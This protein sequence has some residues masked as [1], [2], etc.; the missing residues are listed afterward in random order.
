M[1]IEESSPAVQGPLAGV[2]VLDLSR[3]ISGPFCAK[4]LADFGA[5]VI[6]IERPNGEEVRDVWLGPDG[7]SLYWAQY[8]ANKRAMTLDTRASEARPILRSLV[9]WADVLVEN[10]RPGTLTRMGLSDEELS[11]LNPQLIK[12]SISGFGQF[13]P[14]VDRPLFNAIAEATTGAMYLTRSSS[15]EPQMSGTFMADHAAGLY[16]TIGALLALFGRE[17][18]GS[19]RSVDLAL[20]DATF[21]L[22]GP[23]LGMVLNGLPSESGLGNRDVVTAPSNVFFTSEGRAIYLDVGTNAMFVALCEAMENPRL[24]QDPLFLDNVQ[25]MTNVEKIEA[26]VSAWT[27]SRTLAEVDQSLTAA[28]VPFGLVTSLDEAARSDQVQ[29]R[30]LKVQVAGPRGPLTMPGVVPILSPAPES[31]P[32]FVAA[33]GEHTEEVLIEICGFTT[34]EIIQLR[35]KGVI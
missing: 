16:A 28:G 29:A 31:V 12:T 33:I 22:L 9:K 32:G 26:V 19:A 25:R 10:Y 8:N 21:T 1:V 18:T 11:V 6:K 2:K 7:V 34:E 14:N 15:G 35:T 30:K 13:G 24:V 20:F 17:R 5:D 3:W 4:L 23:S 27:T